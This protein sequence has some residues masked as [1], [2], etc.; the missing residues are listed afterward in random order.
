MFLIYVDDFGIYF[1]LEEFVVDKMFFLGMWGVM[2]V[3]EFLDFIYVMMK[4]SY[5]YWIKENRSKE[6][7]DGKSMEVNDKL[8]NKKKWVR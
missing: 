2:Y 7:K 6:M 8:K 3:G 1:K 5:W 4:L